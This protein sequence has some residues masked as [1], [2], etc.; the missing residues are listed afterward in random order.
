M[1]LITLTGRSNIQTERE[2]VLEGLFPEN[3]RPFKFEKPTVFIT[4]RVHPGE[5][6]AS[7]VLD[8]IL[9]FLTDEKSTQAKVLRSRFTFKII[10][11]LNPDGVFRGYYRL[12]TLGQNLNRYYTEPTSTR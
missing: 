4:S 6:P 9:K 8:G 3:N 10:P 12:D 7:F 2:D 11:M 5:T 1:E